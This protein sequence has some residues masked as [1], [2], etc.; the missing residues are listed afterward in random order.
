MLRTRVVKARLDW[1][2]TS[3]LTRERRLVDDQLEVL[4][5]LDSAGR[6]EYVIQAAECGWDPE[7]AGSEWDPVSGR[8]QLGEEAGA[9]LVRW[10]ET[11]ATFSNKLHG[12]DSPVTQNWRRRLELLETM[13]LK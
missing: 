12:P 5:L 1:S 8:G 3:D 11:G 7:L 13:N 10:A 6:L 9:R 4:R 2:L